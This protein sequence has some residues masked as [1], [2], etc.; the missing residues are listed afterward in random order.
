M[1]IEL[2]K[3][4]ARANHDVLIRPLRIGLATYN[5]ACVEYL[6][7]ESDRELMLRLPAAH[8]KNLRRI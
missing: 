1:L 6:Y 4:A 3:V 8:T 5:F 7:T 2:L